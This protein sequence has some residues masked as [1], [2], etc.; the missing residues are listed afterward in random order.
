MAPAVF[1]TRVYG[2]VG[3]LMCRVLLLLLLFVFVFICIYLYLFVL[4]LP[5]ATL[6]LKTQKKIVNQ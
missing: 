4:Y 3:N 6:G 5:C 1:I 2:L